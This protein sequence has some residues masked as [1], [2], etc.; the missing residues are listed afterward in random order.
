MT[1]T[2]LQSTGLVW[3]VAFRQTA[4]YV[5]EEDQPLW[6][7]PLDPTKPN[8]SIL[9]FLEDCRDSNGSFTFTYRDEYEGQYVVWEQSSNPATTSDKVSGFKVLQW[10]PNSTAQK[11]EEEANF[12]GLALSE[13]HCVMDGN[14]GSSWWYSVGAY[15]QHKLGAFPGIRQA[16]A[17]L[18]L[19]VE[20]LVAMKPEA[21][22][23]LVSKIAAF[24][25]EQ[26]LL[27]F[28]PRPLRVS[29]SYLLLYHSVDSSFTPLPL[30]IQ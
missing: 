12:C 19:K 28:L 30:V 22:E 29:T 11:A 24:V 5:W 13:T 1:V 15:E 18:S 4:P 21:V 27:P 16:K 14:A 20:L 8:Y 10:G 2:L 23:P 6:L 7:N 9:H 25:Q 26:V 3:I 17:E